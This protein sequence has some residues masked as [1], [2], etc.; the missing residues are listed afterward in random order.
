MPKSSFVVLCKFLR[1][2]R[3]QCPEVMQYACHGPDSESSAAEPE[4]PDFVLGMIGQHATFFID[5]S[6]LFFDTESS[7]A[8]FEPIDATDVFCGPN[9]GEI[10]LFLVVLDAGMFV[11]ARALFDACADPVDVADILV[12]AAYHGLAPCSSGGSSLSR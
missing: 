9:A 8:S 10:L 1:T 4:E 2:R 6:N 12:P 11:N 3:L 5:I 7:D